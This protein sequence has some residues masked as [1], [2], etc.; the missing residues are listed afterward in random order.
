M[1]WINGVGNP[2]VVAEKSQTNESMIDATLP[3]THIGQ[4]SFLQHA[5][6]TRTKLADT[7]VKGEIKF[8]AKCALENEPV[9]ELF[10]YFR[11]WH[12]DC[13]SRPFVPTVLN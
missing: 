9:N 1:G 7:S 10:L 11:K 6:R 12:S 3:N 8:S 2:Q 5:H 4:R 13:V